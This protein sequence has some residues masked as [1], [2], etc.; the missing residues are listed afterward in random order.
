MTAYLS[1]DQYTDVDGSTAAFAVSFPFL[2]RLHVHVYVQDANGTITESL[3]TVGW[4]WS[5]D[6]LITFVSAPVA[7]SNVLI[8][9]ETPSTELLV[10]LQG[11]STMTAEENNAIALQLL[12]IIQEALDAGQSIDDLDLSSLITAIRWTLDITMAG[13]NAFA[14]A[15]RIGPVPIEVESCYLPA[16]AVGSSA[17]GY[18]NTLSIDHVLSIRK[19][20]ATACGTITVSHTDPTVITFN[21]SADVTFVAGDDISLLTLTDGGLTNL[22]VTLR[23]RRIPT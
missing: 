19:N 7:G 18:G 20:G 22:G 10:V 21:V 23:L 8:K 17:R 15:A 2:D 13:T 6:E 12:Y 3:V 1:R 5:S 9:R 4:N 16:N 11:Q 14:S